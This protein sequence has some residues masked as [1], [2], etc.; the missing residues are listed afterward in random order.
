[1]SF[2][3]LLFVLHCLLPFRSEKVLEEAKKKSSFWGPAHMAN[4][5][6]RAAAAPFLSGGWHGTR[7]TLAPR[8]SRAGNF[9]TPHCCKP[10]GGFYF[11]VILPH[12]CLEMTIR[13]PEML[14]QALHPCRDC[15][16]RT[17]R[18]R[19]VSPCSSTTSG[20][21][22]QDTFVAAENPRCFLS[23]EEDWN[24]SKKMSIWGSRAAEG[25]RS[26]C[27]SCLHG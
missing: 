18:P 16:M 2:C 19:A 26:Y 22:E 20:A 13:W 7:S 17:S 27:C 9:T 25:L 14:S 15:A 6:G 5:P 8:M 4:P 1:M 11:W 12:G 10:S 21:A 23:L 3:S 24:A